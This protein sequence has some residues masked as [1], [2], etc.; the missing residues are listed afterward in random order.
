MEATKQKKETGFECIGTF[1][2]FTHPKV[3][4]EHALSNY[5]KGN[6]FLCPRCGN[7]SRGF[8]LEHGDACLC[9]KCGLKLQSYGNSLYIWD[10][11]LM[12]KQSTKQNNET[13]SESFVQIGS[14]QHFNHPG[15]T[16][17]A[18][19]DYT[20]RK[21]IETFDPFLLRDVPDVEETFVCP[22]C[23]NK[24]QG[25]ALKHGN[26]YKCKKCGLK[27]QS[28]GNALYIWNQKPPTERL[29]LE[30]I[31]AE[32]LKFLQELLGRD[33]GIDITVKSSST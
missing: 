27:L 14:F 20:L 9:K 24:K 2:H 4:T 16:G 7:S 33:W 13:K 30:E 11:R 26:A 22:Q 8:I 1:Q 10:E 28:Y 25:F 12:G 19:S 5:S 21:K 23:K 29:S 17:L 18:L 31:K 32:T 15:A 3:A 6:S